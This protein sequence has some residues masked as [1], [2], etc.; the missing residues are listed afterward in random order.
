MVK[1]AL[2]FF[3]DSY[4]YFPSLRRVYASIFVAVLALAANKADLLEPQSAAATAA[5]SEKDCERIA[6]VC[7]RRL[8]F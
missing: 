2:G 1:C 5:M 4:F 7:T 6:Q 3:N 8:K